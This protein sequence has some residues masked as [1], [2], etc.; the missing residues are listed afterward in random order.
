MAEIFLMEDNASLRRILSMQLRDS[1]Y[2]V[3]SFENGLASD[4]VDLLASA[5]VLLT[6]LQMPKINGEQVI[7][8]VRSRFP[9]LPIIIISGEEQ[10]RL[11]EIDS[12]AKLRKPFDESQLISVIERALNTPRRGPRAAVA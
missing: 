5:D 12:F 8:N 11:D 6:D 7:A 10:A 4:D 2:N 1:G 9:N 3:T